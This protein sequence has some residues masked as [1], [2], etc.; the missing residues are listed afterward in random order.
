MR[1]L[2]PNLGFEIALCENWAYMIIMEDQRAFSGAVF[3]IWNQASGEIGECRIFENEHLLKFTDEC[4]C[5]FN[6]FDIKMN[7]KKLVTRLYKELKWVSFNEL[8]GETTA[9]YS[10]IY[11]YLDQI[12]AHSP[13]DVAYDLNE[14]PTIL[15][16]MFNFHF[17]Q[18]SDNFLEALIDY[19]RVCHRISDIKAVL[20]VNLKSYFTDEDLLQLYEFLFYE[21]VICIDLE[22]HQENMLSC[23]KGWIIDKDC[24][25]ID[26]N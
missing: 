7:E 6:P 19:I 22:S 10:N 4:V 14:D 23:E 11:S 2:I 16:K 20:F 13:Y 1:L 17:N 9:L 8:Q 26:L 24:C 5:I 15:F 3:D 18:I 25:I 21:K 12:V